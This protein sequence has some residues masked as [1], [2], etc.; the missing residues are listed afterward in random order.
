MERNQW[1]EMGESP[2]LGQIWIE[3][4]KSLGS[5]TWKFTEPH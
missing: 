4:L 3:G 1:H 5:E 2:D